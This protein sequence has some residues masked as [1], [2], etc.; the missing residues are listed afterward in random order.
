MTKAMTAALARRTG[1]ALTRLLLSERTLSRISRLSASTGVVWAIVEFA[2]R[3]SLGILP[4]KWTGPT[5]FGLA[6]ICLWLGSELIV[7]LHNRP[8][9]PDASV[10]RSPEQAFAD[11]VIRYARTL[12][13]SRPPRDQSL[14]H[15]RDWT[16]RLLHLTGNQRH[17]QELG[18]L[19][20]ASAF[21]VGEP[22][23]QAAILIDDLGWSAFEAGDKKIAVTNIKEGVK[24]LKQHLQA[25]L[26]RN[27][28]DLELLCKAQR[29]LANIQ[30]Q[31]LELSEARALL[32]EPRELA[33]K[34]PVGTREL[35][36]AQL[37]H[38]EAAI[39]LT[40]LDAQLGAGGHVDPTGTSS[41]LLEEAAALASSA[42]TGFEK[43]G[44]V[45]RQAKAMNTRVR[46]LAHD[47][48]KTRYTAAVARLRR[49]EPQVARYLGTGR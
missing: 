18:Q 27:P 15:L 29:H 49:I 2:D 24:L 43:L 45:E 47:P 20:L 38:S 21:A 26:D 40:H 33:A 34:L 36:L 37:D 46:L 1:T 25:A 17:R 5:I 44:D 28:R 35:H 10:V 32:R 31:S 14:L 3:Y 22:T 6:A 7:T 13:E 4:V 30:A 12:A 19:A 48:S 42:E 9:L 41:A 16:T 23:T 39:I 11:S 8:E